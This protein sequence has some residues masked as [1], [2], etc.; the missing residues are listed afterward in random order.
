[1]CV[2]HFD[3][4]GSDELTLRRGDRIELLELDEG[5]GDGWY[6]GRHVGDN[7]TG[8]FPGGKKSSD[9]LDCDFLT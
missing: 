4:R 8:I 7:R 3:A 5:F 6:L 9:S 2:D 1:M